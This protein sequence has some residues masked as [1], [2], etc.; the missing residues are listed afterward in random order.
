VTEKQKSRDVIMS[1]QKTS[2]GAL[3]LLA[4]IGTSAM[5]A[6]LGGGRRSGLPPPAFEPRLN[7]ERWTGFY[8]GATIGGGFAGGTGISG[9]FGNARSDNR[10]WLGT[11]M[12]GYNWQIGRTVLGLETDVGTG[13]L[14]G[15]V[16]NGAGTTIR[17]ELN[18]MG[19]FRAR[20][21]FLLTPALMLYGTGGFAWANM[22]FERVGVASRSELLRGYQ[23]GTGAEMLLSPNWTMRLEYV[24]TDLG[25][26]AINVGGSLN[27]FD[28]DFHTVR[29]GVSFKF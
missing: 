1:F 28:T 27:R 15:S 22:D 24:Y 19:T 9:D 5:A 29:A 12:A 25:K 17:R 13:N 8:M 26:D 23:I 16:T 14:G 20:A 6:D 7:I 3:A 18:A 11:V 21:G 2:L 10:G 4:S